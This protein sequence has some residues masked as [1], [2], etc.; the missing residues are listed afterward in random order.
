MT[1]KSGRPR[2]RV[3]ALPAVCSYSI[4]MLKDREFQHPADSQMAAL[5]EWWRVD[6]GNAVC[7]EP[8]G[9]Q[10][11]EVTPASGRD[12]GRQLARSELSVGFGQTSMLQLAQPATVLAQPKTFSLRL[13]GAR[14]SR[15]RDHRGAA[16]VE[17]R[18][19]WFDGHAGSLRPFWT[20][21]L[22]YSLILSP[23]SASCSW[24]AR[25]FEID[26]L[27]VREAHE[28][29]GSTTNPVKITGL[30]VHGLG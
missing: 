6:T 12:R 25:S 23:M 14:K 24:R 3:G 11:R 19:L 15:R 7:D 28:R 17:R 9:R 26:T 29:A 4:R 30:E 20:H 27:G 1:P 22:P 13:R 18:P 2:L 8:S 21:P 10:P 5:A 16:T